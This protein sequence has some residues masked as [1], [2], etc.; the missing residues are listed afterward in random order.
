[1]AAQPSPLIVNRSQDS[2]FVGS[3]LCFAGQDIT[4]LLSADA[5]LPAGTIDGCAMLVQHLFD[6]TQPSPYAIFPPYAWQAFV[7]N[8][9]NGDAV[10]WNHS[11]RTRF[12]EKQV[13]MIPVHYRGNHWFLGVIDMLSNTIRIFDSLYCKTDMALRSQVRNFVVLQSLSDNCAS[14]QLIQ[15]V[16]KMLDITKTYQQT[17]TTPFPF[18]VWDAFPAVVRSGRSAILCSCTDQNAGNRTAPCK[19]MLLIVVCGSSP[20][21]QLLSGDSDQ[22]LGGRLNFRGSESGCMHM[23]FSFRQSERNF[24]VYSRLNGNVMSGK[25]RTASNSRHPTPTS[26]APHCHDYP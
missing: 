19:A 22:S 6:Q 21:W 13:W 3:N 14:K 8:D 5:C 16:Y 1:M 23:R 25:S 17:S 7:R 18:G 26:I 11:R 9:G 15:F 10:I 4:P 2:R 20:V 24:L 12:W